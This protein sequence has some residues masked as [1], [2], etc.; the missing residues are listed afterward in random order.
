MSTFGAS[1]ARAINSVED[2]GASPDSPALTLVFSDDFSTDPNTNGQWTIH[3]HAGDPSTEAVWD[4]AK[5]AFD[6]VRPAGS[7]GAAVFANYELTATTWN[8][9]FRY[10]AGKLGGLLYGGDGFVFMFYKNKA[11]YGI[12]A[13]GAYKGFELSS[14]PTVKGYGLQFDNYI[15]GC[16]PS[17][18]DYY[19][20]IQDD[21]CTFLGGHEFDWIGDNTWH[22]VQFAFAEGGIRI[23]I[24]GESTLDTQLANPDYSFNG[25]GFGAG[26]GSAYGN[27]EIDNFRLWVAE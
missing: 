22:L 5:Q 20:L 1:P 2:T 14:G 16:D 24:D 8:A 21:V 13:A 7:R 19:A 27:Y 26:T 23:T 18:T 17:P 6:L 11:A 3:R 12:P 9:E 25:I 15:Q 4:S 10:R